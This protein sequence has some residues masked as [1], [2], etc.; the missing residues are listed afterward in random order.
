MFHAQSLV[1]YESMTASITSSVQTTFNFYRLYLFFILRV[2][3]LSQVYLF[4]GMTG[5]EIK[6]DTPDFNVIRYKK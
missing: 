5:K 6:T 3:I 2:L 1:W 4:D